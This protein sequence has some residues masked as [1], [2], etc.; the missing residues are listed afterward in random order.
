MGFKPK[1]LNVAVWGWDEGGWEIRKLVKNLGWKSLPLQTNITHI[2]HFLE[3]PINPKTL[4][5]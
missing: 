3:T 1:A 4:K 5:G 2:C